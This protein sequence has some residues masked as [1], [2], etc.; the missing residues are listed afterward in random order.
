MIEHQCSTTPH[1]YAR[2][3]DHIEAVYDWSYP[4]EYDSDEWRRK[5]GS[6]AYFPVVPFSIAN[7]SEKIEYGILTV[8]SK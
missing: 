4:G 6:R 5:S 8:R 7:F 3:N 1:V 2:L